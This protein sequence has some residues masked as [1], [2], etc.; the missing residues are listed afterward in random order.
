MLYMLNL[1]HLTVLQY[2]DDIESYLNIKF[3][4]H[5]VVIGGRDQ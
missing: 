2:R 3:M 4:L 5:N 1:K